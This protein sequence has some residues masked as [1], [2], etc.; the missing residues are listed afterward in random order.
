MAR[1]T[2]RV[3]P[4]DG[5]A[6]RKARTDSDLLIREVAAKAGISR[7]YLGQLE[8]GTREYMSRPAF[9]KLAKA[10]GVT[11]PDSL[12]KPDEP[13]GTAAKAADG[14]V[15]ELR[16]AQRHDRADADQVPELRDPPV[17]RRSA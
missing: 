16:D 11:D 9:R 8:R 4:L 5:T 6:L 3:G 13:E 7:A 1:L 2:V 14:A 15:P 10:L 17:D 12:V